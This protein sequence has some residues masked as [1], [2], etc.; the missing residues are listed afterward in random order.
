[1]R[2]SLL[3]CCRSQPRRAFLIAGVLGLVSGCG[4]DSRAQDPAIAVLVAE[5][6]DSLNGLPTMVLSGFWCDTRV[7]ECVSD[8]PGPALSSIDAA[9]FAGAFAA[10]LNIPLVQPIGFRAPMCPWGTGESSRQGL[11]A[12]FVRP[13][14]IDGDSAVVELST[15]CNDAGAAFEQVHRF[16]LRRDGA[17]WVFTRRDETSIT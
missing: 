12:A 4:A 7:E 11:Y 14:T 15:G 13:P 10:S 1:M 9:D 6:L 17:G 8:T 2:D 5:N 3:Y 16:V